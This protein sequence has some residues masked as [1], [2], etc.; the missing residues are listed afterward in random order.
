MEIRDN[1]TICI[2]APLSI[3][4]DKRRIERL[5]NI[6]QRE[7]RKIAVDLKYVQDCT[8]EF[9]E[10]VKSLSNKDISFINIPSDIFVLFN[11][12]NLDKDVKLFVSELDFEEDNH[13]I[14]NRNFI[15]V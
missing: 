8:F 13:Q 1:K 7:T 12:M 6:I 11:V 5:T 14:I 10:F 2:I 4:I 9:I 15:V 3:K